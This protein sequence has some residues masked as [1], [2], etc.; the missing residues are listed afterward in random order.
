MRR[1]HAGDRPISVKS[2]LTGLETSIG[3]VDDIS[4]A[5]TANN[6]AIAVAVLQRLKAVTD[7]HRSFP[8]CSAPE[9]APA[10]EN[11][12]RAVSVGRDSGQAPKRRTQDFSA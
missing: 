10:R 7:F 12:R 11:S 8:K 2:A 9:L 5:A 6:A 1:S 3:L 4:P